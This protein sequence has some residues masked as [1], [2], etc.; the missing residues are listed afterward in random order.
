MG[1]LDRYVRPKEAVTRREMMT[2]CS[3]A[4]C[5]EIYALNRSLGNLIGKFFYSNQSVGLAE[6]LQAFDSRQP[7]AAF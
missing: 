1:W 7:S 3:L 6:E 5:V 2:Y 4:T